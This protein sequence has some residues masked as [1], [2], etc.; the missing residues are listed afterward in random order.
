M[1]IAISGYSGFIGK[2][3]KNTLIYK[4]DFKSENILLI[5]KED[6]HNSDRLKDKIR[7]CEIIIHLAGV[8]RHPDPKFIFEENV[9]LASVL[10]ESFSDNTKTVLFSSSIQQDLNN[11]FG[12][13]K[14]KCL[15]LFRDW[16]ESKNKNFI[17]L[18]IPNVFGPFCKP[19]YNSFVATFCNSIVNDLNISLISEANVDLIY[20]DDLIENFVDLIVN[21]KNGVL[22]ISRFE[23]VINSTVIEVYNTLKDQW[24]LYNN[25][26]IIPDVSNKFERNLFNTLRSFIN[27]NDFF[28]KGSTKKSDNRGFFSE[29]IKTNCG[30]QFSLSTSR[31][32]VIRGNHFH[33]RKIERFMI[34]EGKA[35]VEMRKVDSDE[36]VECYLNSEKLEFIDIP[37]W[38]THNLINLSK[39]KDLVMLFWINEHYSDQKHDTYFLNVR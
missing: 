8:N 20:I 13:S 33:T 16:A 38:Y 39:N 31:T 21:T 24:Y 9:R 29:I 37:I 15:Q 28:P 34:L 36:I 1:K 3:L 14:F 4:N 19:N 7:D 27:I 35:K 10:I 32:G 12:R 30:G 2:H 5:N 17:N 11:P 26:N 22:E 18:K 25:S 23:N 6:F